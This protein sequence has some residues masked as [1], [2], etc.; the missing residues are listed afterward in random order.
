MD[1]RHGRPGSKTAGASSQQRVAVAALLAAALSFSQHGQSPR[2]QR[3]LPGRCAAAPAHL[4]YLSGSAQG[5][6]TRTLTSS[7]TY[8]RS[9][10]AR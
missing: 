5:V 1:C 6:R 10:P 8:S 2:R 4:Q 3:Q 7:A 9:S